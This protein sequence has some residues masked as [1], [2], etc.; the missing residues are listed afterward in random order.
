MDVGVA[1]YPTF[2]GF[3]FSPLKVYEYMAAGLP[4]VASRVG[5]LSELIQDG[6]DGFLVPPGD[7]AALAAALDRLRSDRGLRT[8]MGSAARLK[9]LRSHTWDMVVRRMLDLSGIA[10]TAS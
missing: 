4:V 1:P 5:D 10:V 7:P 9:V 2:D 8:R 6:V 3:Y